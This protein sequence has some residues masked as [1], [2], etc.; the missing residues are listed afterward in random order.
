MNEHIEVGIEFD[1]GFD[2]QLWNHGGLFDPVSKL[3]FRVGD[4]WISGYDVYNEVRAV[5]FFTQLLTVLIDLAEG[6]ANEHIRLYDDTYLSFDRSGDEVTVAHRY[7]KAAIDNP[8][9]R[10]GIESE[11]AVELTEVSLAAING[12][13]QVKERV[14]ANISDPDQSKLHRLEDAIENARRQFEGR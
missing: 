12:A 4:T 6:E 9:E 8:N 7:T 11:A 14:T 2:R 3:L 10:L 13:E 5:G 1:A